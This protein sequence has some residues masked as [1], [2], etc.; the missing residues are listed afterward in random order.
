VFLAPEEFSG[1]HCNAP[2]KKMAKR[3]K[4]IGF[5]GEKLAGIKAAER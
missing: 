1:S 5:P 3:K 4:K 2:G